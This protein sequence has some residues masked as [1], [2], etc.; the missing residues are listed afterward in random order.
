MSHTFS[1]ILLHYVWSTKDR[2]PLIT[3]EL[4]PSLVKH[5]IK[6]GT[7]NKINIVEINAVSNHVH[8]LINQKTVQSTSQVANL[9]KGESSH[10]I[11][12][13]DFIRLKFA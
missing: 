11:N 6:Y 1:C 4:K 5:I 8:L 7:E 12:S 2:K 9:I 3:K 10:W 13:N